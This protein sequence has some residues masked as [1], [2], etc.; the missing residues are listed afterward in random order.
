MSKPNKRRKGHNY[1][2]NRRHA[3]GTMPGT[4]LIDPS[5]PKSVVSLIAFSADTIK[6][7]P[8]ANLESIKKC[9][10]EFDITWV[11]VSG[12][13]DEN[14]I[15]ELGEFF[16]I[17][18][19]ALE[20]VVHTHQRAKAEL[21]ETHIYL[22]ARF[23]TLNDQTMHLETEQVSLFFG[24]GFVLT[25]QEGV[26][27]HLATIHDRIVKGKGR[28]RSAGSDYLAYALLD[29][30]IDNYF[31]VLEMFGE[32]LEDIEDE[33]LT[34]AGE[35]TISRI[36][37][38]RRSLVTLR[39]AVWPLRELVNVL[40]RDHGGFISEETGIYLRDC[41]DHTVGVID[42]IESYREVASGLIDMYLSSISN[43]MNEIMK[44]LTMI[45][46]I[47]MPL[48]YFAGL[49]GMNFNTDVSPFNMPELNCYFGYPSLIFGML[50]IATGMSL[51]FRKRG[52]IGQKPRKK[53]DHIDD[54][55]R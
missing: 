1:D 42:L 44:V 22:V 14:T 15:L 33:T 48:S 16:D 53:H 5:A 35:S 2:I 52:W 19:L 46:T 21:Y 47:F 9:V 34:N 43:K 20:D 10:D 30:V 51:Y 3:P 31:P 49:Y 13:G 17:H 12:L 37:E 40:M 41:Y 50:L 55:F 11:N 32:R 24:K 39:R 38:I 45:A 7:L 4:L 36:N 28:I 18:R 27:D 23:A 6:Q 54:P 29:A 8:D 25:F 26:I